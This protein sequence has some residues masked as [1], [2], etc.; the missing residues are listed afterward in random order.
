MVNTHSAYTL[1]L[2]ELNKKPNMDR[3]VFATHRT[4]RIIIEIRLFP[5]IKKG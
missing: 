2:L 5:I 1:A 4:S 3:K